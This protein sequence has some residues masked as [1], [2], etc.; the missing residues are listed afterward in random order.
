LKDDFALTSAELPKLYGATREDWRPFGG[1]EPIGD[2]LEK[3]RTT[4]N[5]EIGQY[6]FEWKQPDNTFWNDMVAANEFVKREFNTGELSVVVIDPV[7]MYE[8][9]T[10]L[11]RL[12]LFQDSLTSHNT[13]IIALAPFAPPNPLI[14][15]RRALFERTLPY[16]NDYFRPSVPPARKLVAQC[17]WN[18]VDSEDVQRLLIAAAGRLS[19][20]QGDASSPYTR[21]G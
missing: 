14:Q 3:L 6:R 5:D 16:F 19:G 12:M 13:T 11:P 21:Q 18:A 20:T 17:G 10:V 1:A 15:L 2:V 7:A 8:P 4:I 9:D